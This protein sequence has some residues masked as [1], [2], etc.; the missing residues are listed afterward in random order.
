MMTMTV[1][2]ATFRLNARKQKTAKCFST[3]PNEPIKWQEMT[4][5]KHKI[6]L[7]NVSL[8]SEY[9]RNP[10]GYG[11]DPI[12]SRDCFLSPAYVRSAAEREH[13]M[14]NGFV[15]EKASSFYLA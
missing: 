11:F 6:N 12:S 10:Y 5:E 15:H 4:M 1:V 8:S 7:R 2:N 14:L 3:K 13:S 9:E